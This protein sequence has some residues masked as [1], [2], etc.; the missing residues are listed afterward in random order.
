GLVQRPGLD[1]HLGREEA[2]A[3]AAGAG[4]EALELGQERAA[5]AASSGRLGDEHPLDLDDAV[6]VERP[7]TAAADSPAVLVA[8]EPRGPRAGERAW[9]R[10]DRLGWLEPGQTPAHERHVLVPQRAGLGAVGGRGAQV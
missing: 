5:V 9:R 3:R 4:R 10:E 6:L 8:D 1:E 7:D 2:H